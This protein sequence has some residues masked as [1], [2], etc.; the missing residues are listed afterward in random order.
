MHC[1][2][3]C[4]SNKKDKALYRH[5]A[6]IQYNRTLH[7]FYCVVS[8]Y[9]SWYYDYSF[10]NWLHYKK[11]PFVRLTKQ[12]VLNSLKIQFSHGMN[13]NK[14]VSVTMRQYNDF[15]KVF[16]I[17]KYWCD[18]CDACMITKSIFTKFYTNYYYLM[19]SILF[20]GMIYRQSQNNQHVW[21]A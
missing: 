16:A 11:F 13:N 12:L 21:F 10:P 7:I 6:D 2:F 19:F 17:T 15:G 9:V 8:W 18:I 4:L 5:I 20:T 3:H 1:Q 14:E